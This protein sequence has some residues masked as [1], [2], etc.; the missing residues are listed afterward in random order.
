MK[1]GLKRS[2]SDLPDA[3]VRY[4]S[5]VKS[6]RKFLL[7]QEEDKDMDVTVYCFDGPGIRIAE[8]SYTRGNSGS[9][10]MRCEPECGRVLLAAEDFLLTFFDKPYRPEGWES[11]IDEHG[12]AQ[13]KLEQV[14]LSGKQET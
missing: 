9:S 3:L 10:V 1:K 7:S 4:E 5:A 11:D 12:D 2:L 14:L 6:L 13:W 8:I